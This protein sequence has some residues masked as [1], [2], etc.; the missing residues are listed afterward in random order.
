MAAINGE[1][2]WTHAGVGGRSCH[3]CYGLQRHRK[4]GNRKSRR[5]KEKLELKKKQEE[6]DDT[7]KQPAGGPRSDQ[8]GRIHQQPDERS[9]V[10]AATSA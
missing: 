2:K 9:P 4:P 10:G 3:C 5:R 7:P 8:D 6:Y 1:T